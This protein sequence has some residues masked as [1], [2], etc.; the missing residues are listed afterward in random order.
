MNPFL[1]HGAFPKRSLVERHGKTK[2]MPAKRADYLGKH[3][4]LPYYG[5]KRQKK[6]AAAGAEPAAAPSNS[7]E[8]YFRE[9]PNSSATKSKAASMALSMS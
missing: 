9:T 5:A 1:R 6:S 3:R 8:R 4:L 2:G 7:V